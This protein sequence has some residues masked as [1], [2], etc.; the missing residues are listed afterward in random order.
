MRVRRGALHARTFV[1]HTHANTHTHHTHTHTQRQ[2]HKDTTTQRH[3]ERNNANS[4]VSSPPPPPDRCCRCQTRVCDCT[5]FFLHRG[6]RSAGMTVGG[7]RA[8]Q[9]DV[10]QECM[11][12]QAAY[13]FVSRSKS[14]RLSNCPRSDINVRLPTV[15]THVRTKPLESSCLLHTY[16]QYEPG[17]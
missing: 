3:K 13:V 8:R 5:Y 15:P 11:E 16:L 6:P 14:S 4:H 12:L 2:R 17:S 7:N 10:P 1:Q 9:D